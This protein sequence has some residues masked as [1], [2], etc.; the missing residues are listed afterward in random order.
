MYFVCITFFNVF[1]MYLICILYV[2]CTYF[3]CILFINVFCMYFVCILYVFCMYFVC[4]FLKTCILYVFYMYLNV[5]YK[6]FNHIQTKGDSRIKP[7]AANNSPQ[8]KRKAADKAQWW[9]AKALIAKGKQK[10]PEVHANTN[11]CGAVY[12]EQELVQILLEHT[13]LHKC[14]YINN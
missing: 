9:T 11:E 14:D 13:A 7:F 8:G 10:V 3:L 2:F 12:A 1:C 5:F 4:I 6:Y